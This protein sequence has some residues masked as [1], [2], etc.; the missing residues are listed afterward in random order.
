MVPAITSAHSVTLLRSLGSRGARTVAVSERETAPALSSRYCDESVRVPSPAEDLLG[1]RDALLAV[2]SRSGVRAVAPVREADTYVLSKHGSAFADHVAPLW[3]SFDSLSSVLDRVR[4]VETA[5][6]AG[7]RTPETRTLDEADDWSSR[8]IVKGRYS[9]L[10]DEFV[11]G[12]SEAAD[13]PS[14]RYLEPGVEPDRESLVAEMGH[15]P[16]VQE[17]VPGVEHSFWALYDRGDPVATCQMRQ[18]RA[19]K[20]PGGTSVC[21]ESVADPDLAAAGRALLDRL[22]WHGVA[23]AQFVRH[24]DAG[25]FAL[26]EVNPRFWASLPCAVRAGA[27]FPS[28]FLRLAEGEA[29]PDDE[30]EVGVATHRLRGEAVY[31]YSVLF[32]DFAFVDPPPPLGAFRDV[33]GSLL[34]Q[35]RFDYLT[36]DDPTPFVRDVVDTV[37]AMAAGATPGGTT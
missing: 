2:A 34:A 13:V 19:W 7:V 14:T 8:Q 37:A 33:V 26:M 32:E 23:S 31:L 36:L 21:R 29:V 25:E 27:D 12:V 10:T 17:Y 3:P 30:Y 5:E 35:P 22:D 9:L 28:Y 6:S 11:D 20:Y 16:I 4:L 24:E 15:V 1:Y 18:H